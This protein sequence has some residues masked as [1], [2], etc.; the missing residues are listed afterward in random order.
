M[1]SWEEP[2]YL[3]GV[4]TSYTVNWVPADNGGTTEVFGNLL[5]AELKNLTSCQE[6]TVT[7][8][9]STSAGEGNLSDSAKEN[10]SEA[11][12]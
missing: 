3:N 5:E 1:V 7:V 4:I 8:F 12:E 2:S 6:Y 11:S 9:G 10:T